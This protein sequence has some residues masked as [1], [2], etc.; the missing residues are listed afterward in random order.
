MERHSRTWLCSV[1][2][3]DIVGYTQKPV[4]QQIEMKEHLQ[5]LISDALAGVVE[6]DRI[7]VD[8]GDGA[9]LCF[10]GDPEEALFVAIN[11]RDVLAVKAERGRTPFTTRI[12][13]NLGPVTRSWCR[14]LSTTS[15]PAF[16]RSMRNCFISSGHAKISTSKST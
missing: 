12:G 7:L 6:S 8:T 11:L 13:I 4:A 14:V 10:L 9:A 5:K 16:R 3:L 15:S 1:V 2:F